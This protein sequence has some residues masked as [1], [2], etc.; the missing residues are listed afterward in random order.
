MRIANGIHVEVCPIIVPAI[1]RVRIEEGQR[2]SL[3]P[4]TSGWPTQ[5]LLIAIVALL[6]PLTGLAAPVQKATCNISGGPVICV[7]PNPVQAGDLLVFE[8]W[9]EGTPTSVTDTLGSSW[10]MATGPLSQTYIMYAIAPTAGNEKVTESTR[11]TWATG[12]LFEYSGFSSLDAATSASFNQGVTQIS[13]GPITTSQPGDLV[14]AWVQ[15]NAP[16]TAGYGYVV[17]EGA[18]GD[19]YEDE[20]SQLSGPV[21]GT[22]TQPS[23]GSGGQC[24]VAA[25]TPLI[26]NAQTVTLTGTFLFDNGSPVPGSICL[27]Q[28]IDN[29]GTKA[30]LVTLPIA[31]D[32]SISGSVTFNAAIQPLTL[33]ADVLGTSGAQV[34]G[35]T[36]A[37]SP[38]NPLGSALQTFLVLLKSLNAQVVLS[39]TSNT[40]TSIKV[41][42][43]LSFP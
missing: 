20:V 41:T 18:T 25:F 38:S 10:K 2:G 43:T 13:C 15:G 27:S 19:A 24:L 36:L 40:L 16:Y 26:S 31:A 30:H 7:L 5:F 28:V 12:A 33:E 4:R 14:V 11:T 32:G 39:H 29:N 42:P 8:F 23:W 6:L 1:R 9:S 21:S 34:Y 35:V 17:E 22:F 3:Q 37:G